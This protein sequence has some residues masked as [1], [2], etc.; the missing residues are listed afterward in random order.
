MG[1]VGIVTPRRPLVAGIGFRRAA[2]AEAIAEL[3]RDALA[4]ADAE[5]DDV[6]VIATALDRA[7]DPALRAAAAAFGLEPVGIPPEALAAYD[8]AL[9]HR[10]ERIVALRGV[11]C[12]CEAAALACAGPGGTLVLGRVANGSVTCALATGAETGEKP[13]K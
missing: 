13:Q 2:T 1:L 4:R 8:A 7:G 11:G 12:L 6:R 9:S 3:I 5:P 10:S